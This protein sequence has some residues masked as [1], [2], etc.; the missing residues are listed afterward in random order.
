MTAASSHY[1]LKGME[2]EYLRYDV[3]SDQS[4]RVL[5]PRGQG[6]FNITRD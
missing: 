5:V 6:L 4:D 1:Y 2:L 3:K